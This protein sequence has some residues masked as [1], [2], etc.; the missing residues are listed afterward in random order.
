V[1]SAFLGTVD[2]HARA[3]AKGVSWRIVGTVD[4]FVWSLLISHKAFQASSIASTEILT[5][6]PLYY[7]H[8]RAWRLIKWAPDSHLRSWLKA[9]SWRFIGGLDTFL[10]S[11]LFTGRL[12]YAVS[13]TGA[14][15]L[16]KI[17]LYYLHERVWRLISWGRLEASAVEVAAAPVTATPVVGAVHGSGALS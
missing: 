9:I 17:V 1:A 3:V 7:L 14:E 6:I 5:K 8:E 12:E 13:I 10:R 4:T 15:T 11:W 2:G 16:T